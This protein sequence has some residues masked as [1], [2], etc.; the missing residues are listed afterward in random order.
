VESLQR[1]FLLLQ[2]P[3]SF[4]FHIPI[5]SSISNRI[6]ARSSNCNLR[7]QY[8]SKPTIM[9]SHASLDHLN[10]PSRISTKYPNNAPCSPGPYCTIPPIT[11]TLV[12]I[13]S[14]PTNPI[15]FSNCTPQSKPSIPSRSPRFVIPYGVLSVPANRLPSGKRLTTMTS[16]N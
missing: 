10:S 7:S 16:S 3:Q 4:P 5:S 6:L 11:Q 2:H 15:A 1:C 9:P 12:R 13:P 14:H 8:L